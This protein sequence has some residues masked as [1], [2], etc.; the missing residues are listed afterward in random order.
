MPRYLRE[1]DRAL[2]PRP[3]AACRSSVSPIRFGSWIGGDRDGNPNV[4]PEVTRRDVP[5][6]IAGWR[7]TCYLREIE[8][9]RDEL[10]IGDATPELRAHAGTRA[11]RIGSCCAAFA[12]RLAATRAHGSRR[13]SQDGATG[14]RRAA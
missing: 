3:A 2:P 12:T 13:R 8:A 14:G 7:P 10:S 4:T 5:A 6:G 1:V 11:S 9:L